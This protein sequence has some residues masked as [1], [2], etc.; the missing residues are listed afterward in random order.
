MNVGTVILLNGLNQFLPVISTFLEWLILN[1]AENISARIGEQ[2]RVLWRLLHWKPY[3]T[4]DIT[5]TH[6]RG[7][8][9]FGSKERLGTVC[10]YWVT[11]Y[12][13][14]NLVFK[15]FNN[16]IHF[17]P[18]TTILQLQYCNS[19][20]T[21]HGI[22]NV[23]FTTIFKTLY[24]SVTQHSSFTFFLLYILRVSVY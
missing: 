18:L 3:S 11:E 6:I 13:I 22:N 21:M 7:T 15:K 5:L 14:C 10:V 24:Q 4:Y 2:L 8:I 17:S 9:C 1:S 16:T 12:R 19:C 23:K 20:I